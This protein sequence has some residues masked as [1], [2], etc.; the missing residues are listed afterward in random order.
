MFF[1]V[2]LFHPIVLHLCVYIV[3]LTI[4]CLVMVKGTRAGI[5][6]WEGVGVSVSDRMKDVGNIIT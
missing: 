2:K 5:V 3:T 6:R 1:F 4:L